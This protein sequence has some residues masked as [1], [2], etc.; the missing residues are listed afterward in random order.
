MSFIEWLLLTG[1]LD[2]Y[3]KS[4]ATGDILESEQIMD[5]KCNRTRDVAADSQT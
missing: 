4:V 2:M 3:N 5:R 1:K